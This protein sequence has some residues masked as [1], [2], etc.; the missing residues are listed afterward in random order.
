MTIEKFEFVLN[1]FMGNFPPIGHF[2]GRMCMC[3]EQDGTQ[4]CIITDGQLDSDDVSA[5]I[6]KDSLKITL[7]SSDYCPCLHER[8]CMYVSNIYADDM[9]ARIFKKVLSNCTKKIHKIT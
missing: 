4:T 3:I 6:Y 9:S 5:Q 2:E 8:A 7:V 1:L